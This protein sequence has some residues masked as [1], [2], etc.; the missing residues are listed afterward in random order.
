[1]GSD[2][3]RGGGREGRLTMAAGREELHSYVCMHVRSS[4]MF[5]YLIGDL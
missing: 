5:D 3:A 2:W 4:S 1:M